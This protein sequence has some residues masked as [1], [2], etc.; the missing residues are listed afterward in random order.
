MIRLFYLL[1]TLTLLVSGGC[2]PQKTQTAAVQPGESGFGGTG[3]TLASAVTSDCGF[4]GTGY[5]PEQGFGGTGHQDQCGFGGTGVIGTITDFG[6]IWVNGL[7]IELS[8]NLQVQSNLGT[9]TELKIGHQVITSVTNTTAPVAEQVQVHYVLAGKVEYID[10]TRM[11]I[12]QHTVYRDS[13]TLGLSPRAGD[14]VA[15]NALPQAGGSWLATR[16]DPNPDGKI[17]YA[18]PKLAQLNTRQALLEGTVVIRNQQAYLAPYQLP[19]PEADKLP[20]GK[21]AV[22]HAARDRTDWTAR[23]IM[24]LE[25]WRADWQTLQAQQQYLLMQ[26]TLHEQLQQQ[27]ML[28]ESRQLLREQRELQSELREYQEEFREKQEELRELYETY[29]EHDDDD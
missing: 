27:R 6:S 4:G 15:I 25:H 14:M 22:V 24:T 12:N 13:T 11:I 3:Y 7:R 1:L 18:P 16:I 17:F 28:Q 8:P 10:A 29:R 19:L 26:K 5:T 9:A 21:P 20:Q 23:S 2:T